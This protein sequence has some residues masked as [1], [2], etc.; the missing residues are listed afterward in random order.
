METSNQAAAAAPVGNKIHPALITG[1]TAKK[2]DKIYP[3][4]IAHSLR[5]IPTAPKL[6][7]SKLKPP[8][9][10]PDGDDLYDLILE[11]Q[12]L[13]DELPIVNIPSS[14]GKPLS[15]GG[16]SSSCTVVAT[17]EL[18]LPL[19]DFKLPLS[20]SFFPQARHIVPIPQE[21]LIAVVVAIETTDKGST[22]GVE[23]D[24]EDFGALLVYRIQEGS[25]QFTTIDKELVK[26]LTFTSKDNCFVY[27]CPFSCQKNGVTKTLLAAVTFSGNVRVYDVREMVEVMSYTD[28]Q[29]KYTH[30]VYCNG[31][32]KLAV[33]GSE[34]S[35]HFLDIEETREEEDVP[36]ILGRKNNLK[37]IFLM[38]LCSYFLCI[39]FDVSINF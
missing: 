2:G 4:I 15:L 19:E 30:C 20:S 17:L 25:D 16:T 31:I 12:L 13:P 28:S 38:P 33:V 21:N 9:P 32:E 29:C 10:T 37:N 36:P 35:I 8:A 23:L 27:L 1:C 24:R 14:E 26:R 6:Q 3:M 18:C 5:P 7:T 39:S 22:E 34:S 11:H